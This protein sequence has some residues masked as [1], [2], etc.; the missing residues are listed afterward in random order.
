MADSGSLNAETGESSPVRPPTDE[1]DASNAE[2][3]DSETATPHEADGATKANSDEE[4]NCRNC[5]EPLVGTYCASC[6]QRVHD[7]RL[8][9][10]RFLEDLAGRLFDLE[11][12]FLK[13][14]VQMTRAPGQVPR[15][16][17]AGKRAR[18]V[19]PGTYLVL[20]S[21]LSIFAFS[22]VEEALVQYSVGQWDDAFQLGRSLTSG[23]SGDAA[24]VDGP[25]AD[26]VERIERALTDVVDASR[27]RSCPPGLDAAVHHAV[28]PGG[29]RIRPQICLAVAEACRA[30]GI[31]AVRPTAQ[32]PPE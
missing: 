19:R 2:N 26:E 22:L 21:A 27:G 32:Y 31:D 7:S 18:Y 3:A 5:G 29:A 20:L 30:A 12:G 15:E 16:Y 11:S 10:R 9:T 25:Q 17:V 28:F 1:E 24:S 6:G 14:L 4:E 23:A 8:T 13:T